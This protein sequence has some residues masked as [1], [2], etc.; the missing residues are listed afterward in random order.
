MA[1]ALAV[2]AMDNGCPVVFWQLELSKQETALTLMSQRPGEEEWW[3]TWDRK[4]ANAP[5]PASWSDLLEIRGAGMEDDYHAEAIV[6]A[7]VA[8]SRKAKKHA[9]ACNGLLIV[10][11]VQLLTMRNK[12]GMDAS[13]QVLAAAANRITKAAAA[14]GVALVMLSQRTKE[15][16]KTGGARDTDAAGADFGPMPD[17]AV[18]IRKDQ[19]GKDKEKDPDARLAEWTKSRGTWKNPSSTRG[20]YYINRALVDEE[21]APAPKVKQGEEG[22][23]TGRDW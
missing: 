16:R 3:K 21:H 4:R 7:I 9:H 13:H 17:A 5:A 11:Y 6:E 22:N 8:L 23:Q 1:A 19:G 12:D 18:V 15:A 10:D 14:H 2:D 20:L